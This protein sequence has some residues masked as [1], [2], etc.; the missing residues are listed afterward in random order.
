M[1]CIVCLKNRARD[2]YCP[3]CEPKIRKILKSNQVTI[4]K[5]TK[6][7]FDKLLPEMQYKVIYLTNRRLGKSLRAQVHLEWTFKVDVILQEY[8]RMVLLEHEHLEIPVN[9]EDTSVWKYQVYVS[10]KE[11]Y[12]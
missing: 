3:Y 2:F 11:P 4:E 8:C 12:K 9:A 6:E 10:P 1:Y 7:D 5:S